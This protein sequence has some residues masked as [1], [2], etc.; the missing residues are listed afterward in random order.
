MGKWG[1]CDRYGLQQLPGWTMK[2]SKL[3]LRTSGNTKGELTD[4]IRACVGNAFTGEP[5]SES[6]EAGVG[7]TSGNRR[8]T[9]SFGGCKVLVTKENGRGV[10]RKVRRNQA[11][12]GNFVEDLPAVKT[13]HAAQRTHLGNPGRSGNA[14]RGL[15]TSQGLR[16]RAP[17]AQAE[18]GARKAAVA[19]SRA[20]SARRQDGPQGS[21]APPY[22]A[23]SGTVG[24]A[25]P[26][27]GGLPLGPQQLF[28][29]C[30]SRGGFQTLG[31]K[32]A[33]LAPSGP[34][35]R[36]WRAYHW[37]GGASACVDWPPCLPAP[38]RRSSP[39]PFCW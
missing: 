5:T 34:S 22:P 24:R 17:G 9:A 37:P 28:P 20:P 25:R 31:H 23:G 26:R 38:L 6:F 8:G 19:P 29:T 1:V 7:D 12:R 11:S 16:A 33:F 30:S 18:A 27:T 4:L 10:R 21:W 2:G 35:N 14:P 3:K 39:P 13:G 36:R 15:G 32:L